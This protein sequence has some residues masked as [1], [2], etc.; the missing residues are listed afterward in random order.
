MCLV[1]MQHNLTCTKAERDLAGEHT[2]GGILDDAVTIFQTAPFYKGRFPL[3][4]LWKCEALEPYVRNGTWDRWC[5][6]QKRFC[7][8]Y[9]E[10]EQ[11]LAHPLC[12][13]LGDSQG[14]RT[15]LANK[16]LQNKVRA[17]LHAMCCKTVYFV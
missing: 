1:G 4:H 14:I 11:A 17:I 15:Y 10:A 3:W 6:S 16:L 13:S 12:A 8:A 5:Q 7:E 9:R 2:Y